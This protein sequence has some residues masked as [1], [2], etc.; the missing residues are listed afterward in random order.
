MIDA[1]GNELKVAALMAILDGR[2]DIADDDWRLAGDVWATSVQ[3]RASIL[4]LIVRKRNAEEAAR[5]E[6]HANRELAAEAARQSAPNTVARIAVRL[7]KFV[8]ERSPEEGWAKRDLRHRLASK[9]KAM[10]QPALDHAGASG[11]ITE[12]DGRYRPGES[13]PV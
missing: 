11:W 13:K 8:H 4:D 1:A 7:A 10:F 2:L 5:V 9:E 6:R 12:T 3:V